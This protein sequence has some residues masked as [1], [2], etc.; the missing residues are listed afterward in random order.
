MQNHNV[1]IHPLNQSDSTM[2]ETN[3]VSI[4]KKQFIYAIVLVAIFGIATGSVVAFIVPSNGL[5][6]KS[7][8]MMSSDKNGNVRSAGLLD[9]NTFTDTAEGILKEGGFE[10]EGSYNLERGAKDQTA[11][12]T[13]SSVDLSLFLNKKVK[14]WGQTHT[15]QK[16]SWFMDVGYIELME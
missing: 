15:S 2:T 16:V 14:V 11:Y 12:L 1:L 6:T 7:Q 4:G 5:S 9:K 10:G 8:M 13:S 3:A